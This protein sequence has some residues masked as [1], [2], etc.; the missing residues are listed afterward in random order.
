MSNVKRINGKKI[1]IIAIITVAALFLTYIFGL[2]CSIRFKVLS[3]LFPD[4]ETID[5][6]EFK[7]SKDG[8]EKIIDELDAVV[9]SEENFLD[10]YGTRCAVRGEGFIFFDSEKGHTTF[11]V[12]SDNW[13]YTY[14][15]INDFPV[16]GG[17]PEIE[18]YKEF[19]N[20]VVFTHHPKT[21]R[22]FVYTR[23][24][25]PKDLIDKLWEEH[26]FVEVER[27]A[28]G[29]YDIRPAG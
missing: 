23:G 27:L 17:S 9:N 29:W 14:R 11:R 28:R 25:Y 13:Y 2:L 5:F 10:K 24:K 21:D 4:L 3:A 20:Y 1:I 6:T 12:T 7:D 15:H 16:P 22:I 18:I 8:L 19:P 26:D